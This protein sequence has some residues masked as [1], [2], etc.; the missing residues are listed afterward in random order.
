MM[1]LQLALFV[2]MLHTCLSFNRLLVSVVSGAETIVA[3][4]TTVATRPVVATT[5]IVA[6]T[7]E[8]N[9]ATTTTITAFT[10]AANMC[11]CHLHH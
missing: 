10:F 11:L 6:T 4:T 3:T 9:D 1:S 8:T 2:C 7:T 5:N